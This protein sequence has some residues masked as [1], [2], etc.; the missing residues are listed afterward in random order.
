MAGVTTTIIDQ[1]TTIYN[2]YLLMVGDEDR[3]TI[4][5]TIDIANVTGVDKKNVSGSIAKCIQAK[6][7]E[8]VGKEGREGLYKL[9]KSGLNRGEYYF[10]YWN[11]ITNEMMDQR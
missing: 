2:S 5:K 9:T 10:K 8:R 6:L 1:R 4:F 11:P 7:I 3:Y